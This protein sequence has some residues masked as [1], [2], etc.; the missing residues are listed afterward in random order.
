MEL[1]V[2][3]H[4][5]Q[6]VSGQGP[7]ADTESVIWPKRLIQDLQ[8]EACPNI[9][10]WT[11]TGVQREGRIRKPELSQRTG[12]RWP[13]GL[14]YWVVG[15]FCE[16]VWVKALGSEQIAIL[17]LLSIMSRSEH[18]KEHGWVLSQTEPTSNLILQFISCMTLHT[19]RSSNFP[20]SPRN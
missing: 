16:S 19:P 11:S 8:L 9:W 7:R 6:R 4:P 15:H 13:G 18:L 12:R 2:I 10:E 20:I 17:F 3:T 1:P 14:L 5:C